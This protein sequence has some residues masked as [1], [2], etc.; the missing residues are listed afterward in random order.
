M[1]WLRPAGTELGCNILQPAVDWTPLA[2]PLFQAACMSVLAYAAQTTHSAPRARKDK[3][4]LAADA[5]PLLSVQ[6]LVTLLEL[7]A[8]STDALV[9]LLQLVPA[10][11]AGNEAVQKGWPLKIEI[12]PNDT[13]MLLDPRYCLACICF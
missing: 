10:T 1:V 8:S 13:L 3:R 4:D 9:D 7:R 11:A 12:K 5:L 6:V 2:A